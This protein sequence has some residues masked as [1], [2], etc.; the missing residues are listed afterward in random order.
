M[1]TRTVH[2][3]DPKAQLIVSVS[4][5]HHET[6]YT[7]GEDSSEL[8]SMSLGSQVESS[9]LKGLTT[10]SDVLSAPKLVDGSGALV[11]R[12]LGSLEQAVLLGWAQQVKKG[13]SADE[14]Q[15][16][17]AL[18]QFRGLLLQPQ[19]Y[20]C[21]DLFPRGRQC[22]D[23]TVL[24][25][26]TELGIFL[27]SRTDNSC[28]CMLPLSLTNQRE[29][30]NVAAHKTMSVIPAVWGTHAQAYCTPGPASYNVINSNY[31]GFSH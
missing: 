23:M 22:T 6:D 21:C 28:C 8:D 1:G 10:D 25:A 4:Q 9:E 13:T 2:Q 29:L 5:S 18:G 11:D 17:A 27:F 31:Q 24:S 15:V 20:L 14:L 16:R 12:P 30:H 19:H 26:V 3:V 7:S